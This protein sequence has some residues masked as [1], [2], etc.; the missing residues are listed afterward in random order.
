MKFH[1]ALDV[2]GVLLNNDYRTMLSFKNDDGSKVSPTEAKK[3]LLDELS[4]GHLL[5]P[6]GECDNFDE[7]KG[8]Q[9][10]EKL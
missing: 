1:V 8:C 4:K 7:K 2:K 3:F 10:H 5:I 6:M 9:G